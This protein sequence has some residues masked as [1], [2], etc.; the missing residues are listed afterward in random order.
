VKIMKVRRRI[1]HVLL[2]VADWFAD[3][4]I[5]VGGIKEPKP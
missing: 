1:A 5:W 3:L 2:H 4:A